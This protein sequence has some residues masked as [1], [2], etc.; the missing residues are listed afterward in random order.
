M[1]VATS[2]SQVSS[3][4]TSNDFKFS[5]I[6]PLTDHRGYALKSVKSWTQQDYPDE[7]YEVI[8]ASNTTDP[9]LNKQVQKMLRPCDRM[10]FADTN[11]SRKLYDIGVRKSKNEMILFTESHASGAST[12][13][14][15]LN[16]YLK[17]HDEK[18]VGCRNNGDNDN[19]LGEF[20][21]RLYFQEFD[22]EKKEEYWHNL[23]VRG[24]AI[25]RKIYQD[26][27]GFPLDL[28]CFASRIFS[29]GIFQSGHSV[30]YAEKANIYHYN[31][32]YFHSSFI[33]Q[34]SHGYNECRY[35]AKFSDEHCTKYIGRS[36]EWSK[37]EVYRPENARY[38]CKILIKHLLSSPFKNKS[39][40][41]YFVQLK[42]LI[43]YLP[44]SFLG[45]KWS[46][47]QVRFK[48]S[49]LSVWLHIARDFLQ[50]NYNIFV[51][52]W[53]DSVSYGRLKFISEYLQNNEP[54][55]PELYTYN[56]PNI[57]EN[58]LIGF[59]PIEYWQEQ[60]FRW[61]DAVSVLKVSL[62]PQTYDVTIQLLPIRPDY[63]NL[64]LSLLFNDRTLKD[65][66]Y[67]WT[68]WKITFTVKSE[69]FDPQQ[70]VQNL[71][72]LCQPFYPKRSGSSDL[73]ALGLPIQSIDFVPHQ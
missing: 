55:F 6:F 73:R 64:K 56:I 53:Y 57:D 72:L 47:F 14:Q 71:A 28:G 67:D 21:D 42:A 41:S 24:F 11:N 27:G 19:Y 46:Y 48:I 1:T 33:P 62:P 66:A 44:Y 54:S 59:Y 26:L 35:R 32:T 37:R 18:I 4:I 3:E 45:A 20:I 69:L 15:E 31:S 52:M 43:D 58:Y 30:G 38:I 70:Q 9:T 39:K 51:E 50:I 5:I 22:P 16:H 68:Q 23:N 25:P 12:C 49:L 29:L 17:T 7:N 61:S 36:I 63:L 2:P 8:V 60:D 10:I 65:V 13:L 40:V 34:S